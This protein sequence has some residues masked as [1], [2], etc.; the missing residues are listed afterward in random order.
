MQLEACGD[1]SQPHREQRR[2]EVAGQPCA[3]IERGR[4]RTPD[5]NLEVLQEEGLE[6]A[7]ALDVV[8]VEVREEDVEAAWLRVRAAHA[9]YARA[10]IEDDDRSVTA[11]D[12]GTGGVAAV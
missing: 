8:H 12:L 4:R 9:A 11:F 5:V 1:I 6:E 7:E 2:R 10:G 3:Q